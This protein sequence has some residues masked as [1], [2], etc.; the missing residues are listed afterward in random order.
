MRSPTTGIC[1]TG[2]PVAALALVA[3]T[4]GARESEAQTIR[5]LVTEYRGAKARGRIEL[6]NSHQWPL[7]AVIEVRGFSVDAAGT[8]HDAPMPEGVAVKLSAMSVRIP[9]GQT[10]YVFYE[11][12]TTHGPTWFALQ[13]NLTGYPRGGGLRGVGLQVELPHLVYLLHKSKLTRDA[14]AARVLPG[15]A[16]GTLVVEIDNQGPDFGRLATLELRS[17]HAKTLVP[18]GAI[19]PRSLRRFDLEWRAAE[20]PDTLVV[21]GPGFT[22]EQPLGRLSP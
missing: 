9:P 21:R 8:V 1:W 14:L 7:D 11:A 15:K 10:R 2:L 12:S 4:F 5:P 6:S 20:P 17:G 19:F 16:S 18:G 3:V 22:I 13:A